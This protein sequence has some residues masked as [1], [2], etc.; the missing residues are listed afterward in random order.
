MFHGRA[1]R[2][3]ARMHGCPCEFPGCTALFIYNGMAPAMRAACAMHAAVALRTA[4]R[5]ALAARGGVALRW[6]GALVEALFRGSTR[7]VTSAH[8]DGLRAAG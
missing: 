1:G 5:S 2:P 7:S 3:R 4:V 8:R 6:G